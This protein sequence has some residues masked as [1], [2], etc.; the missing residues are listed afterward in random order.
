MIIHTDER[1]ILW[2]NLKENAAKFNPRIDVQE[3]N[4]ELNEDILILLGALHL[5][6]ENPDW[7]Q[8]I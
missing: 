7:Y 1:K 4:F 8:D 2:R 3:E 6:R 5:I